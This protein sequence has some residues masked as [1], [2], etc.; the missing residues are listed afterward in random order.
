MATTELVEDGVPRDE[1]EDV[2]LAK[3]RSSSVWGA[4]HDAYYPLIYRYAFIRLSTAEDAED[5][6]SQVFLEALKGI[7]RFNYQGKPVLAW[8]YGIAG[9]LVK[10]RRRQL[11]RNPL[12]FEGETD[13]QVD[14]EEQNIVRMMVWSALEVLKDEHREVLILRFLLDL[15][16]AQVAR[17]I[18]KTEAATYS[19]QV[20]ALEAARRVLGDGTHS[21]LAQPQG[22]AA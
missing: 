20:R 4:W 10:K 14:E 3:E 12:P 13:A 5:L 1:A 2:R 16:N 6:A 19:L 21:S 18:G 17:V 7:D 22:K 9:N 8:F 11:M 15:P